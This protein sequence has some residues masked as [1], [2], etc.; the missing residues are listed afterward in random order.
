MELSYMVALGLNMGIFRLDFCFSENGCVALCLCLI[1]LCSQLLLFRFCLFCSWC[2]ISMCAWFFDCTGFCTGK[3]LPYL[4]RRVTWK[5]RW[6]PLSLEGN[7]EYTWAWESLGRGTGA[8]PC[9]SALLWLE[10]L[11]VFSFP[12]LDQWFWVWFCPQGTFVTEDIFGCHPEEVLLASSG[13]KLGMPEDIPRHLWPAPTTV[14]WC[15]LSVLPGQTPF[16]GPV[17][18]LLK[19][20]PAPR[21]APRSPCLP[22]F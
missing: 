11:A 5:L 18:D 6:P 4:L 12:S 3:T 7:A 2:L 1:N 15:R 17:D 13:W 10:I 20:L 8:L 21:P 16:G 19:A 9:L 22:C 14:V